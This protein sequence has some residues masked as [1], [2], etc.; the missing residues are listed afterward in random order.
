MKHS[1][2]KQAVLG[3]GMGL[4]LVVVG[5][6]GCEDEDDAPQVSILSPNAGSTHTLGESMKVQFSFRTDDFEI[7][8]DCGEE[9]FCGRAFLN[10]DGGACNQPGQQYNNVLLDGDLD[11]TRFLDALFD[12]CPVESRSG[13]HTISISLHFNDGAAVIGEAG[14]QAQATISLQT[15]P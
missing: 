6:V 9:H 13:A 8:Q 1:R 12:F 15:T 5:A 11:E 7:E 3:M 2:S 10:I 4:L 14:A